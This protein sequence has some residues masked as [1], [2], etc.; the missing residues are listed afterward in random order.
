MQES[1]AQEILACVGVVDN[2]CLQSIMWVGWIAA[3]VFTSDVCPGSHA[4]TEG[5]PGRPF[6][7]D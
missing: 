1:L 3:D 7:L 5:A 4:D 6:V 2:F